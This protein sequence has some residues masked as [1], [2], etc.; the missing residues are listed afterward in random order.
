MF[1]LLL[2]SSP[3]APLPMAR[4]YSSLILCDLSVAQM[5]DERTDARI[6][7]SL[8]GLLKSHCLSYSHL[9]E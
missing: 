3:A 6:K 9:A 5:N 7:E 2:P 4:R 1:S 8:S